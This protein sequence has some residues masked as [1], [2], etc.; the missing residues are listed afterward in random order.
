M[1]HSSEHVLDEVPVFIHVEVH[2]V[3]ADKAVLFP[4][5]AWLGPTLSNG[6]TEGLAVIALVTNDNLGTLGTADQY[7]RYLRFVNLAFRYLEVDGQ[8]ARVYDKVNFRRIPSH[9]S[10]NRR[11]FSLARPCAV[12]MRLDDRRIDVLSLWINI[13]RGVLENEVENLL[14]AQPVKELEYS[15]PS[16]EFAWKITPWQCCSDFESDS[17]Y[18]HA[19]TVGVINTACKKKLVELGPRGVI[20]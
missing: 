6:L 13:L 20:E 8:A 7:R 17:F 12:L 14:L 9:A 4:W 5:N 11:L 1:L 16:A 15:V 18:S 19:K 10:T 2:I 3:I